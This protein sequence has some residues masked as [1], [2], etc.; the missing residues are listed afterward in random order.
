MIRVSVLLPTFNRPEL[1]AE[2]LASLAE[3]TVGGFEVLVLNDGGEVL[4]GSVVPR[5]LVGRHDVA[6]RLLE[7]PHRGQSAALNAGLALATGTYVTVAQDDDLVL[8]EKIERL[9]A[10]LDAAGID[11]GAVYSLPQYTDAGGAPIDAPPRLRQYLEAHPVLSWA[12]V[13]AS[14]LFVHGTA[15]MYRRAALERID[16][17]DETLATAEEFD[18]HLRLLQGGWLFE[19]VDAVTVTYRQHPG[20]KSQVRSRRRSSTRKE[21]M[22][23]IYRKLGLA[24]AEVA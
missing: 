6:V 10:A 22:A 14:G 18:L 12:T 13:Q 5:R 17:W 3:Q 1:L 11:A 23:R 9:T 7:L 4:H 16:G 24:K 19:A 8:P 15:T 21:T 2:A 20:G